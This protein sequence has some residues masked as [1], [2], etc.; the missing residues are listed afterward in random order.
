MGQ[1]ETAVNGLFVPEV[2]SK[3]LRRPRTRRRCTRKSP[4]DLSRPW[5]FSLRTSTE[6]VARGAAKAGVETANRFDLGS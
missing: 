6:S 1:E 4:G 3:E 2:H 5:G